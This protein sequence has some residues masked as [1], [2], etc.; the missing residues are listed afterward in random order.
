M[1]NNSGMTVLP[2]NLLVQKA[3]AEIH[4]RATE[5]DTNNALICLNRCTDNQKKFFFICFGKLC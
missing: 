5:Y 1:S 4:E 2:M 3:P